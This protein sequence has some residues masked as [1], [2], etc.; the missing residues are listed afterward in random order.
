MEELDNWHVLSV[1]R[2]DDGNG[3]F[4]TNYRLYSNQAKYR[5]LDNKNG[6]TGEVQRLAFKNNDFVND[7]G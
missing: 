6:G 7:S 3:K 5:N 1:V 4:I 2:G